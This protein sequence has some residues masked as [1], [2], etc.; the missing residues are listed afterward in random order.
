VTALWILVLAFIATV[1]GTALYRRVALRRG[2]IAKISSRTLHDRIVPRGGGI[3]VGTVFTLS[4]IWLWRLGRVPSTLMLALGV[5]GAIATIAG[6]LDDVY[7]IRAARKLLVHAG[8]A[9]LLVTILYQPY[10]SVRLEGHG[11]VL[12]VLLLGVALFV[13]MWLINLY[14]FVDGID[15]LAIS[16]S[17]FVSA[18]AMI[19]IALTTR[20]QSLLF[21]FAVLGSISLGFCVWNLPPARIFMGDA[22]SIFLGYC[23]A[24]LLLVTVLGG[25]INVWTWIILMGYFIADTT[26]TTLVRMML[27]KNWYGV[28]RSHA[29]QNLARIHKSH[30]KVT[31]GVLLFQTMWALPLAVLSVLRPSWAVAAA[32]LCLLP[33]VVWSLK[34][35]PRLSR[36]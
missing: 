10:L 16:G 22:G 28:H 35:G 26:I 1:T 25:Q 14:N 6:F 11:P 4:M 36:E 7:E 24:T 12:Q 23:F 27:V 31:Y 9:G 20:D 17:V 18:A 30:G 3:I 5:G 8:L 29:Y 2:I 32:A 15:G 34:F 19:V 21:V 33:A 13:P